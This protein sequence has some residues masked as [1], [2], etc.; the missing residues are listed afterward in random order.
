MPR[1]VA[2]FSIATRQLCLA[3]GTEIGRARRERRWSQAELAGRVG[4]SVGTVRAVESGAPSVTLGVAFEAAQVLGLVLMG[5]PDVA[6]AR[7]AESRRVMQLLPQRVRS[8]SVD[9]D[10]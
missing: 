10:F 3:L 7:A 4:V 6:A 2:V 8:V 9:D 1:G 5:G